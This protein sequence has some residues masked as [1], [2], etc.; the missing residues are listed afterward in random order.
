MKNIYFKALIFF[1]IVVSLPSLGQITGS[2]TS[3]MEELVSIDKVMVMPTIDNI[4]GIYARPL[5]RYLKERIEANHKLSLSEKELAGSLLSPIELERNPKE[6]MRIG[7]RAN[8]DGILATSISKNRSGVNL[9]IN[10]FSAKDGKLLSTEQKLGIPRYEINEIR[11]YVGLHLDKVLER[12]PYQGKVLS[13]QGNRVTVNLGQNDGVR[14]DQII[15]VIQ[16]IDLKRHPKFHFLV[17]TEKEV[18]GKI[19][20]IKVD[21]TLSFGIVISE[22]EKELVKV[23]SKLSGITEVKYADTNPYLP[24][25]QQ[26]KSQRSGTA[27]RIS[28][29]KNPNE[30][31][32]VK[33]PVFGAAQLKLGLGGYNT[34][35][36]D[37]TT[38]DN[39][40][41]TVSPSIGVYGELW[42]TPEWTFEAE[43]NQGIMELDNPSSTGPSSLNVTTTE[44]NFNLSYGFLFGQQFFGP[45]VQ[46]ILGFHSYRRFIDSGSPFS[47]TNYSGLSL[48]LRG[49]LPLGLRKEYRF[50]VE[51]FT[52]LTGRLTESPSSTG[53]GASNT[54][55]R[56]AFFGEKKYKQN[57]YIT[58]GVEFKSYS[59]NFSSGSI[60]Q[61]HNR[62]HGGLKYLF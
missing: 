24:T 29:G 16:V 9:R 56:Y 44:Y 12:L 1:S 15:S 40:K 18:L 27:N 41:K 38:N 42:L 50:G 59:T 46:A 52:Q 2:Y 61:R 6:V 10:L 21:E 49:S 57:I 13:R 36:N 35:V 34:G 14:P 25:E 37:G 53:S 20:L 55:S 11:N 19:K 28:F 48:G 51:F 33:P 8:V 4:D 54:I 45:K 31:V 62:F 3:E 60:S 39:A 30:W 22:K 23:D 58:G 7:R 32:P 5:D 43:L 26:G 17:G 47:T